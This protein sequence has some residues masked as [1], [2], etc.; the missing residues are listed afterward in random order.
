M[1]AERLVARCRYRRRRSC[2]APSGAGLQH[3]RQRPLAR[4]ADAGH[5]G[6]SPSFRVRGS[7]LGIRNYGLRS[8]IQGF[9]FRVR[10][11][12]FEDLG[13]GV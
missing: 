12:G 11:L 1:R 8:G 4:G 7:G 6:R 10:G 5:V 9:G 3:E 13:F 2:T